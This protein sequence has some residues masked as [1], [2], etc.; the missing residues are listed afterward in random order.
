MRPKVSFGYAERKGQYFSN[1]VALL[2]S[3]FFPRNLILQKKE[4]RA[5]SKQRFAH[6]ITFSLALL[7]RLFSP[8]RRFVGTS[9]RS[10]RP[11]V[12][13]STGGRFLWTFPSGAIGRFAHY[14]I[15]FLIKPLLF[16]SAK[17]KRRR[18]KN[19]RRHFSCRQSRGQ[20]VCAC[21]FARACDNRNVMNSEVEKSSNFLFS[22]PPEFVYSFRVLVHPFLLES[23][24]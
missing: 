16:Q 7:S 2:E 19:D 13:A 18:E 21:V 10:R 23:K 5:T 24:K 14:F 9:L 6:K 11:F 1:S 15:L 8:S 3:F 22:F 17:T 12:L 20:S 4:K